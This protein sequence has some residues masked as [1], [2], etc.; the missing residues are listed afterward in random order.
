MNRWIQTKES[1]CKDC[2]KC[3]RHC[4]I[5]AIRIKDEHA[6]IV[7]ERCILDGRCKVVCPQHA[8][9][10]ISQI[11]AVEMAL[12]IG[13][14]V[15]VSLAPSFIA[16]FTE[17]TVEEFSNALKG[18][19]F[20]AVEET[21]VAAWYTVQE[22]KKL[23]ET[24]E[25]I[26]NSDCPSL[27]NLVRFY[28]PQYTRYLAP[29]QS[30]MLAHARLLK[31]AYSKIDET[32]KVVFVGPCLAK[33]DEATVEGSQVDYVL[34]FED[35]QTMLSKVKTEMPRVTKQRKTSSQA[36]R[37]YPLEGGLLEQLN[38][39]NNSLH[40]MTV[41]GFDACLSMLRVLD[42]IKPNL[43]VIEMMICEYGCINGPLSL[44]KEPFSARTKLIAYANTNHVLPQL[45]DYTNNKVD[46]SRTFEAEP[47]E[48]KMPSEEEIQQAL[49]KTD[50]YSEEDELNCG[51]CGYNSCREK[52]V[53]VLQGMAEMDMCIPYMR[54]KAELRANKIIDHDPNGVL[55]VNENYEIV[56]YNESFR[57]IYG[58]PISTE[59]LGV[60][61]ETVLHMNLFSNGDHE[62]E[63]EILTHPETG[64][65]IEV[66]T[67]SLKE[68]DMH[69]A[70]VVD[71]TSKIKQKERLG[72]VKKET[73][74]KAT[75]VIHRQMKVAHEIASLLGET[76]AETKVTL[77]NLMDIMQ[78]EEE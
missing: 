53:A 71:I 19:G 32:V 49:K 51:A 70:I 44:N 8:K 26:I 11:S 63:A 67:F 15:V 72:K 33:M 16:S 6:C 41:S 76:T 54:K 39:K 45:F 50:K 61:A 65:T 66:L 74:D 73:I 43:E 42:T 22:Y 18:L 31:E 24:R 68:D 46:F 52:A 38:I 40:N 3:V 20:Y 13:E 2:Y 34:S 48:N 55:E 64:K 60:P 30:P 57:K 4:P 47:I 21:A 9:T 10:I 62:T 12:A 56:Q 78:E 35:I 17:Y 5:K 36:L 7:P 77:L 58:L 69:V 75:D 14:K 23:K 25:F 1:H 27:V 37:Q 28:F 29:I 59:L